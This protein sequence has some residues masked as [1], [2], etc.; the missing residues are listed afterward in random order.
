MVRVTCSEGTSWLST[1]RAATSNGCWQ[2]TRAVLSPCSTYSADGAELIYVGYGP[3]A[4][5]AEQGQAWD[6]V[7]LVRY[8]SRSAFS[9]MDA[10][11]ANQAITAMRTSALSAAVLHATVPCTDETH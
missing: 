4:L 2:K 5:V 11:P 10:D 6:A 8:P 3:T 1:R 9:R 7:L